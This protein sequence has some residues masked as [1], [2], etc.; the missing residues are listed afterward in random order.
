MSCYYG[1]E[2]GDVCKR[3]PLLALR[4]LVSKLRRL[5]RKEQELAMKAKVQIVSECHSHQAT[6]YRDAADLLAKVIEKEAV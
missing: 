2:Y 1:E 5:Q 6:G 4:R 3:V